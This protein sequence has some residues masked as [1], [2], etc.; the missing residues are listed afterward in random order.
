SPQK[1][2]QIPGEVMNTR[3]WMV[4]TLWLLLVASWSAGATPGNGDGFLYED[5]RIT[6]KEMFTFTVQGELVTVVL[7]DFEMRVGPRVLRGRDAVI[8]IKE[9]LSLGLPRRDIQLYVEGDATVVEPGG[10]TTRDKSML[11]T[12]RQQGELR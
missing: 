9:D 4:W 1:C 12:V 10:T 8:W 11:V 7:G 6:G 2:P 3:T 5:A